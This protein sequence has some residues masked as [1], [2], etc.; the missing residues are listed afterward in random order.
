MKDFIISPSS[1]SHENP[2]SQ[3][4][5][6]QQKLQFLLQIQSENW[7]Y[8]ILWQTTKDEKGKPFLSWGEGYFQGTKETTTSN[9]DAE[10]FYVMSLTRKFSIGNAS[11]ISLPGKAFA[12]DSVLWL[13]SKHELQ[14]YNCERSNEAH[15]HGIETLICIPTTNG[16]IEM[17]SYDNIQQNW[18]LVHQAKSMFQTS[19]SESNSNL[20]LTSTTPFDKCKTFIQ[21][22]SFANMGVV[23][24]GSAREDP[25][26][27]P[28]NLQ[29]KHKN[30]SS[31]SLDSEDSDSEYC[32]LLAT[33]TTTAKNDSFEK[34]EPKKRGRKPLTG[35]QTPMNHV[36]A[37][38]QRREK[39][40]HRFYALRSVVPNVSKMDKASL[41]SDAVDYI[42]EL[43]AK[44]EDLKLGQQ[45]E[46]KKAMMKTMKIVDNNSAT[47]T[48]IVV[49]QNKPSCSKN[50]IA[51]EIDVKI[52]GHDAMVRVQSL[53]VNHP[54]ARLMSVLKDLEYQVHQASISTV[55]K[56]VMVQDVIVKVPNEMRNEE[57]LI[58]SA[59]LMKL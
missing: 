44:I 43:K 25:H 29:E 58:R 15:M 10:W 51:L 45:K 23:S 4:P 9:K 47:T 27:K 59:I 40:N 20:D 7:I 12:L 48:S 14:I 21:N 49:D 35:T 17:G 38:R 37:E 55:N 56:V 36:E 5:T 57:S 16:V 42:N 32:P 53:N 28:K 19:S 30:V 22:T 3:T 2:S 11:S 54:S 8:G 6:L 33:K 50:L 26:E 18:N 52:I 24:G 39:L 13:N 41:L 31:C 1:S 34:R 46:S